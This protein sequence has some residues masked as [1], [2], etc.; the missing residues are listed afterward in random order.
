M[1]PSASLGEGPGLFEPIHGSAPAIAGQGI[2]NP[3]GA[4]ASA[5]MLL[6]YGLDLA[7]PADAIDSGVRAALDAGARTK[8]IAAAGEKAIG[9]REMGERIA[10]LVGQLRPVGHRSE[11]RARH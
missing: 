11:A 7:E 1:L 3:I 9:T 10:E 6:R 8:D 5:A 2:A 4:I